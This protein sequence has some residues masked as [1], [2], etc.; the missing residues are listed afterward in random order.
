MKEKNNEE[1][2]KQTLTT[3]HKSKPVDNKKKKGSLCKYSLEDLYCYQVQ[4]YL[5]FFSIKRKKN[6]V[7]ANYKKDVMSEIRI[8]EEVEKENTVR[9]R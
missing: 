4:N 2:V 1:Q 3:T 5:I 7:K 8:R 6:L 9:S